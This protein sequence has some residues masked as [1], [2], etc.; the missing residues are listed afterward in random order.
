MSNQ[1]NYSGIKNTKRNI[2]DEDI[3]ISLKFDHIIDNYI[4]SMVDIKNAF[5]FDS[6]TKISAFKNPHNKSN[7][8]KVHIESLE[9]HFNIPTE[10]FDKNIAIEEMDRL[11]KEYRDR[12]YDKIFT[13]ENPSLLK[14]IKGTL[15]AHSYAS[16]TISKPCGINI[17]KTIINEDYSVIDQAGNKGVLK[18]GLEQSFIIKESKNAKNFNIIRFDNHQA[19]YGNFRF[20]ILSNQNGTRGEEM[21]NFGFY[22]RKAHTPEEAQKIL[23]D[24]AKVQLK[25][26]AEF[27][28]RVVEG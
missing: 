14:N 4:G 16:R 9:R 20:V 18:V 11:I 25:L 27:A 24:I 21:L 13:H 15:Y 28:K 17:I 22:S 23:G 2:K 8:K 3:L 19:L 1:Q 7:L 26:D 5:G 10:V 6:M 12:T